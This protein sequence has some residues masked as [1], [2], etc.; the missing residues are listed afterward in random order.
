V[1][2]APR[3]I[4]VPLQIDVIS[5]VVCPWCYIGKR[6]LARA[7]ALYSERNPAAEAPQVAWHPFQLNPDMPQAGLDRAEYLERKFGGRSKDIY[8]RVGAVGAQVGIAF[9]FD[10]V[11][12]QP[13]TL[14]A[15]SLI[16]LA[17]DAGLQDAAVEALFNAYFIEGRDLTSN[18]TLTDIACAAG[19]A[20]E[21]VEACLGSAQAREHIQAEDGQA[22]RMGVEG[23]PFFVINRRYAVSGAQDPEVLLEAMLKAESDAPTEND[24]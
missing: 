23:V 20:K 1:S 11:T 24:G 3:R 16:A 7:L 13:N 6:K 15:H 5:D 9:A 8:A 4:D 19:L 10:K 21:E 12:R 17:A 2:D 14:A 22:R 18:Q